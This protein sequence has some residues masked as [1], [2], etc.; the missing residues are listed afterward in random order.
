MT[1][2][3][4]LRWVLVA[5]GAL[6]GA[7]LWAL[8]E[9]ADRDILSDLA[10]MILFAGCGAFFSTALAMTGPLRLT[11]ALRNAAVIGV[12]VALL[13]Y[14]FSLRFD[15]PDGIL[16]SVFN[17]L[18]LAAVT[19]LPV[20]FLI[21]QGTGKGWRDYPALF[22]AVST[23]AVRGTVAGIFTGIIWGVI[24]LSDELLQ[25]VGISLIGDIAYENVFPFLITGAG[26]GLALGVVLELSHLISARLVVRL[27]RL[28][29]PAVLAVS[30]IF[31][32]AAPVQGLSNLFRGWSAASVLMAMG[33]A[34]LG[35]LTLVV[36]RDDS[37]TP[38]SPVLQWAA[39]G[40]AL[41]LP[42]LGGLAVWAVVQ[43]VGQY[44]WT[45]D[46]LFALLLA[47]LVALS[48]LWNALAIL[49][50]TGWRDR[51]RQGNIVLLLA[52]LGL[53]ALWLTPVLNAERI[54]ARSLAARGLAGETLDPADLWKLEQWGK[55]GAAARAE[56]EAVAKEPGH[57]ALA[58]WLASDGTG[59]VVADTAAMTELRAEIAEV[60]T[61]QPATATGTRDSLLMLMDQARLADLRDSCRNTLPGGGAGCVMVVAD[62]L[63]ALPGE[64]AA[65]G[66]W[67]GDWGALN[68]LYMQ[69]GI[70][71]QQQLRRADGQ[72][73]TADEIKATMIAWGKAPPPLAPVLVNQLGTGEGGLFITP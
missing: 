38:Q 12:A 65:L 3:I 19:A 31:V 48:G 14:L 58:A 52:V 4:R 68:G 25:I 56:F 33:L 17:A 72:Y 64:E 24:A 34:A 73:L 71:V 8:I 26:F 23:I 46:R 44:G 42:V 50:R 28:L 53:A 9:A 10:A 2:D 55:A 51:I 29:A 66:Q 1:D 13:T 27:M 5:E 16:N 57:E 30:V 54:S 67:N 36:D 11:K 60:M 35:L 47:G 6:A 59:M 45:P 20:P 63:P 62:L 61:L 15:E 69:D 18:A 39:R 7:V 43:R 70:V 22:E 41:V 21:A 49:R 40:L 37:E 32:V